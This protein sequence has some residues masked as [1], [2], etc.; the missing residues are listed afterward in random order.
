M[1]Q[2]RPHADE[3]VLQESGHAR[4]TAVHAADIRPEGDAEEVT[5][6]ALFLTWHGAGSALLVELAYSV[7]DRPQ[8]TF[9]RTFSKILQ[10]DEPVQVFSAEHLAAM[11]SLSLDPDTQE[12]YRAVPFDG[13]R[14]VHLRVVV[15][16]S[17]SGES[18]VFK[19]I[20]RVSAASPRFR[21]EPSWASTRPTG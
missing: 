4:L 2:P 14:T 8:V 9:F 16:V 12:P 6:D 1:S 21:V 19:L 17:E 7:S 3:V 13:L 15:E 11:T 20:A 10:A 5:T 18:T